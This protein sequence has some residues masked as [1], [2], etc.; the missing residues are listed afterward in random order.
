MYHVSKQTYDFQNGRPREDFFNLGLS[1]RFTRL[2][3]VFF[4]AKKGSEF[5]EI[6]Y[7]KS[8]LGKEAK[9]LQI[10]TLPVLA[11]IISALAFLAGFAE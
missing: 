3:N 6:L 5:R 2:R 11:I 7:L 8:Y 4:R 10:I 9:K 1:A